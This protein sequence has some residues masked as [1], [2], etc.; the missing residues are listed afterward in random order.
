VY[1]S[2]SPEGPWEEFEIEST[3]EHIDTGLPNGVTVYYQ[4]AGVSQEAAV[5]ARTRIV[6]A[7]PKEDP[8]PPLGEVSIEE[9]ENTATTGEVILTLR[10]SEDT[11]EMKVSNSPHFDGVFWEP[12]RTTKA[13]TLEPGPGLHTVYVI[14]RDT[15]GN[16]GPRSPYD[17]SVELQPAMQSIRVEETGPPPVI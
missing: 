10:A 13:W 6:G 17:P 3:T 14:F 2:F 5:S 1:R 15:A 7:M 16:T 9:T 8:I 12:F 11:V 4:V